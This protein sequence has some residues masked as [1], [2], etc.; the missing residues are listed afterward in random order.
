MVALN[1]S[2]P[3][4]RGQRPGLIRDLR[5][6]VYSTHRQSDRL[7]HFRAIAFL[8]FCD[9]NAAPGPGAGRSCAPLRRRS[10]LRRKV[11]PRDRERHCFKFASHVIR[12]ATL[13]GLF[14]RNSTTTLQ[15]ASSSAKRFILRLTTSFLDLMLL[16]RLARNAGSSVKLT[17]LA[18]VHF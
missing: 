18:T 9:Q 16:K 3:P 4:Q 14:S 12:H 8:F 7:R 13:G 15:P 11:N 2:F 6:I 5:Y 17:P 1:S 10:S